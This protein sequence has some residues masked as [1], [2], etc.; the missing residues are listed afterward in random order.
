MLL[1]SLFGVIQ[2]YRSLEKNTL[3]FR[4]LEISRNLEILANTVAVAAKLKN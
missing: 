3:F 2:V 1:Y 4:D